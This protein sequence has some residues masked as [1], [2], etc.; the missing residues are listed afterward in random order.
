MI[1]SSPEEA[2]SSSS[3]EKFNTPET[4]ERTPEAAEENNSPVKEQQAVPKD[5]ENEKTPVKVNK[6]NMSGTLL[7][8]YT[9]PVGKL[10]S[11]VCK[12]PYSTPLRSPLVKS[13]AKSIL[14]DSLN[15]SKFDSPKSAQK[16]NNSQMHLID[17]T[18]P[19]VKRTESTSTPKT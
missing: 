13:A 17:L 3:A 7:T 2:S 8:S 19:F 15:V 14:N 11:R 10:T 4:L 12:T 16:L 9:P 1:K 5:K 18:T 6:L